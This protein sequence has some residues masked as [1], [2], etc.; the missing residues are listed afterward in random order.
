MGEV[1]GVC[2]WGGVCDLAPDLAKGWGQDHPPQL[3]T[4]MWSGRGGG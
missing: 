2:V 4:T 3:R 1:L